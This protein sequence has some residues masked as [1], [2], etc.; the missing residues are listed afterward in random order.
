MTTTLA[1]F[2]NTYKDLVLKGVR[3]LDAPPTA[4]DL[5]TAK[6]PCK[7]ADSFTVQ[8]APA[9]AKGA[10][11]ERVLRCRVVVAIWP[12]EQGTHA[13]RWSDTITMVDTLNAGIKN[14]CD[15]TTSWTLEATPNF[16]DGWSYAVVATI[17]TSEWSV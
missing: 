7:W 10:G 12:L 5:T 6:L 16:W 3:N 8:E 15:K 9:R 2:Y 14:V 17:E 4:M 1:A 11:G 13:R